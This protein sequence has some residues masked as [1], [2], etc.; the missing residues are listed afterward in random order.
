M[1]L[2][3]RDVPLQDVSVVRSMQRRLPLGHEGGRNVITGKNPAPPW[4]EFLTIKT[5]RMLRWYA[6]VKYISDDDMPAATSWPLYLL[7]LTLILGFALRQAPPLRQT[8][9]LITGSGLLFI[10]VM[11]NLTAHHDYTTMY[12]L[13]SALVFWL[14]LLRPLQRRPRL[15]TVL[16][17]ASLAL[18][19]RSSLLVEAEQ[20]G[21][22]R[23][24][25][26]YG[27]LQSHPAGA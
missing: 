3:R 26:L 6:P 22:L 20:R 21:S 8:L 15:V 16:L 5:D 4:D 7:A 2:L 23:S 19:L 13:G 10:L 27:R 24:M 14:A 11:I 12:A 25:A 18:F 9:L 1:E 17:L